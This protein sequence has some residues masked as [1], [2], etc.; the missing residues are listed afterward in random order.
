[1]AIRIGP[2][3]SWLPKLSERC[4]KQG[5]LVHQLR[6]LLERDSFFRAAGDQQMNSCI[7]VSIF[8]RQSCSG[9]QRIARRHNTS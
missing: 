4:I 7:A 5:V 8:W 6:Y 2:R 1:M 9:D 3:P